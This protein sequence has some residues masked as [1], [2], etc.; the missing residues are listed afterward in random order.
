MSLVPQYTDGYNF[1]YGRRVYPKEDENGY[2]AKE[3]DMRMYMNPYLKHV[4]MKW[5]EAPASFNGFEM[6][7][8]AAND[9]I[10]VFAD[11]FNPSRDVD[12][13]GR[14]GRSVTVRYI[15]LWL[16]PNLNSASLPVTFHVG[17]CLEKTANGTAWD[18]N[19]NGEVYET[20]LHKSAMRRNAV[21]LDQYE[22]IDAWK[23][24]VGNSAQPTSTAATP[25]MYRQYATE[26]KMTF[27]PEA[28]TQ[29]PLTF[30]YGLKPIFFALASQ[31]DQDV[32]EGCRLNVKARFFYTDA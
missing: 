17:F 14:I 5:D 1:R 7:F 27:G 9:V 10:Q 3:Q 11:M 2:D 19:K 29:G 32:V 12:G 18:S 25:T 4:E 21:Y 24:T 22:E 13:D 20:I 16:R 6:I 31:G 28:G 30:P 8:P 26:F 15:E 23:F